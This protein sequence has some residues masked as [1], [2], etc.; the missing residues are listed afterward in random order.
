VN[1]EL[2][3]PSHTP[4]LGVYPLQLEQLEHGGANAVL[5][6]NAMTSQPRR[7]VDGRSTASIEIDRDVP[8]DAACDGVLRTALEVRFDL[9]S[10][11]GSFGRQLHAVPGPR[12]RGGR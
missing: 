5:E 8:K 2:A 6:E 7:A 10:V 12:A 1:L 3:R 11:D 4:G 9:R